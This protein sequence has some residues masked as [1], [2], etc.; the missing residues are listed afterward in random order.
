MELNTSP[1]LPA[2]ELP[3]SMLARPS[4]IACF[5]N[6]DYQAFKREH[7][8][9]IAA[10]RLKHYSVSP[11]AGR[12][13]DSEPQETTDAMRFG[14]LVHA[15]ALSPA[16]IG[17]K[18]QAREREVEKK[19]DGTP[20]AD[21]RQSAA[22]KAEWA[23]LEAQGTQ[24]NSPEEHATA[25]TMASNAVSAIVDYFSSEPE[26]VTETTLW[27]QLDNGYTLCGTADA[28]CEEHDTIVDIKTTADAELDDY[29]LTSACF[30]YGYHIQAGVYS[31]LYEAVCGRPLLRFAFAFVSKAA[32]HLSKLLVLDRPQ[33]DRCE[34]AAQ[35]AFNNLY[36][37]YEQDSDLGPNLSPV[38]PPCTRSLYF[39]PTES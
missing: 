39:I 5:N 24:I 8:E 29:T 6:Y 19:K 14:S 33:L 26:W 31:M 12:H 11:L 18:F 17:A 37:A 25:Q 22:Q 15:F 35:E 4:G 34:A 21:G 10:S 3:D 30:R 32:P 1:V 27:N 7:P 38:L 2:M 23:E 20:Y 9:L 28:I 36:D 16:L 13:A